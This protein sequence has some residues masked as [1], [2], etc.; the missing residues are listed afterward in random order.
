MTMHQPAHAGEIL[1]YDI[2]EPLGITLSEA[3]SKLGISR[4]TLSK[5]CNAKG[6]ITPDMAV[7]LELALGKPSAKHWLKLQTA[8]DLAKANQ[9]RDVLRN[10]VYLFRSSEKSI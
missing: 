10:Q 1:R 9:N 5:I 8:Y 4:K 7:R 6:S 3:A 2:L